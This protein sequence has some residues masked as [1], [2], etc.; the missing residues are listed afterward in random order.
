MARWR[1]L[2]TDEGA[3]YDRELTIDANALEPMVTFGTNPGMGIPISGAV[4]DPAS[5][6]DPLERSDLAKA[7][8]YMD[9]PAGK[10]LAG[11]R[12]QRG[13]HRKLHQLAHLGSARGG[14]RVS[15]AAK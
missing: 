9:L 11:H 10:P 8:Q 1:Q 15:R 5:L 6:S 12:G 2:P 14:V 13:V 7:L 4:P 3:T